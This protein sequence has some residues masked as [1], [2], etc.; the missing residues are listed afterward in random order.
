MKLY[1]KYLT[2]YLAMNILPSYKFPHLEIIL[3]FNSQ[4]TDFG[5]ALVLHQSHE[6]KPFNVVGTFGYMAP[7]YMMYG[8]VDEKTD[9]YSFGVVLLELITGKEAIQTNLEEN[10]ASLVLWVMEENIWL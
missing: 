3:A 4:L 9:V 7:E 2:P 1:E 8:T 6:A 10:L 5:S